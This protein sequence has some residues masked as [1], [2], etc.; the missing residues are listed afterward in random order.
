MYKSD[1]LPKKP[2][3]VANIKRGSQK[4]TFHIS[5]EQGLIAADIFCVFSI[6]NFCYY[7]H[8]HISLPRNG[9]EWYPSMD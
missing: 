7:I 4:I 5:I 9:D 2:L 1:T 3:G 8:N 6:V